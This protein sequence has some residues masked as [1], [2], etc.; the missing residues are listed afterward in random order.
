MVDIKNYAVK[1]QKI[2]DVFFMINYCCMI[3]NDAMLTDIDTMMKTKMTRS[4]A[5]WTLTKAHI[6]EI[7]LLWVW[8]NDNTKF[9]NFT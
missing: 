4:F 8:L 7:I 3:V 9:G 1:K 5:L 2:K 6:L